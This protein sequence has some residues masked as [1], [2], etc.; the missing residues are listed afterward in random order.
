MYKYNFVLFIKNFLKFCFTEPPN[1]YW[2]DVHESYF[3]GYRESMDPFYKDPFGHICQ[4]TEMKKRIIYKEPFYK[5]HHKDKIDAEGRKCFLTS[6]DDYKI[7][8]RQLQ[9]LNR[10]VAAVRIF[11]LLIKFVYKYKYCS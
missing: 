7:M 10:T 11:N 8:K 1:I 4:Y 2:L 3:N 5:E 9:I 6:N